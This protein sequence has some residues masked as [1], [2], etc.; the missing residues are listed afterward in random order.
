MLNWRARIGS[1]V[2]AV[3][4]CTSTP[5]HA[6]A[7]TLE[8]AT[9]T[10]HEA[11]VEATTKENENKERRV[12]ESRYSSYQV[13]SLV[14]MQPLVGIIN[15]RNN[16]VPY[17]ISG[18]L[19]DN[20]NNLMALEDRTMNIDI[21]TK[22]GLAYLVKVNMHSGDISREQIVD[23]SYTYQVT[24]ST[25]ITQT[26]KGA[27]LKVTSIDFDRSFNR[28]YF[29]GYSLNENG[30]RIYSIHLRTSQTDIMLISALNMGKTDTTPNNVFHYIEG[31]TIP[32][33]FFINLDNGNVYWREPNKHAVKISDFPID[34]SMKNGFSKIETML[35]PDA[36]YLFDFSSC[37]LWRIDRTS[38]EVRQ[39]YKS[40]TFLVNSAIAYKGKFYIAGNRS[41]YELDTEGNWNDFIENKNMVVEIVDRMDNLI[42]Q[43]V[44]YLK[45]IA[46][47]K[48]DNII[49]YNGSHTY[50]RKISR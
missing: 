9:A 33:V 21:Q 44:E 11:Q 40:D 13:K 12:R 43:P 19:L 29:S 27:D 5:V 16:H 37:L 1:I 15:R 7:I 50:I 35:T 14:Y 46:F 17:P 42:N 6:D 20:E 34:P 4:I 48:D 25:G 18:I 45:Y 8:P 10:V 24:D 32:S 26:M 28:L 41:I 30:E 22:S 3:S 2:C 31:S 47:D 38:G 39:L 49:Y 23:E 36:V